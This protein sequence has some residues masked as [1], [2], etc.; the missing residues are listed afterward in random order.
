MSQFSITAQPGLKKEGDYKWFLNGRRCTGVTTALGVIEKPAL[1]GWAAEMGANLVRE[2]V[3]KY[4]AA[5]EPIP[6]GEFEAALKD[7]KHAYKDSRK[8][9]QTH[10]TN[11]DKWV[12]A[13]VQARIAGEDTP[14]MPAESEGEPF[15][16]VQSFLAW[17]ER[18]EVEWLAAQHPAVDPD[19]LIIGIS[20][21]WGVFRDRLWVLDAK[22]SKWKKLFPDRELQLSANAICAVKA[23]TVRGLNPAP[24]GSDPQKTLYAGARQI[25]RANLALS[26]EIQD[27]FVEIATDYK[28]DWENVL[29]AAGLRQRIPQT[30]D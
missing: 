10:G 5:G 24:A 6:S 22:A 21:L 11:V 19:Y 2:R 23:G 28:D 18:E 8:K 29:R 1:K 7:A 17:E 12:T 4:V 25:G 13:Y 9:A 15:L 14:A 26:S 16:A 30:W 3:G 20:D 27:P